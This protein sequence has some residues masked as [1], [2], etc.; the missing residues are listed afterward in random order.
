M[1]VIILL[2]LSDLVIAAIGYMI[3]RRHGSA[4]VGNIFMPDLK[5]HIDL[6]RDVD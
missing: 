3:G 4:L 5:S 2:I 1:A 6:Q